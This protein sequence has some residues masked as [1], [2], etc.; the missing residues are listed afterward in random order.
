VVK[1]VKGI[2]FDIQRFAIY[3]GPGIR[4]LVFLKG[5]PLRCWWCQ[6][7]EGL[8]I[9][10]SLIYISYKCI[11]CKTC[12]GICPQ[13]ALLY[14]EERNVVKIDRSRC[15]LCGTCT[16]NCPTT[17]LRF[18]GKEMTVEEVMA[19][20]EK[21]IPFYDASGG[22]V[23]FSGGE[24]L[25]QAGFLTELLK[26]CRARRIHTAIET[27][28]YAPSG[29]FREVLELVD[30]LLYDIKLVDDA[31]HV[32]YTGVS[33]KPIL[34]NL[35]YANATGKPIIIR[36]PVIPTITDTDEN[37][38]SVIDLLSSLNLKTILRVD[39]LPYHDVREK[40]E[41]LDLEYKMPPGLKASTDRLN[42]IKEEIEKTGL[43]VTVGGY[44]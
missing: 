40:Y 39:L 13:R 43:K 25:V 1:P 3:D 23:T 6:N 10:P 30:L 16:E 15:N 11:R 22:G 24:P 32:K 7:P 34:A 36:I 33:N 21:D 8:T 19:E 17:A 31:A 9:E 2:V 38:K 44:G 29:V 5:C 35:L 27:S 41:R 12:I 28:G 26:A 18:I 20:I 14:D 42:L 37:L 4:T